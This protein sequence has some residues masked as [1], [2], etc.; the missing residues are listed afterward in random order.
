MA[1][2]LKPSFNSYGTTVTAQQFSKVQKVILFSLF[3]GALLMMTQT[4]YA[5]NIATLIADA[6]N[7]L[8]VALASVDNLTRGTKAIVIVIAFLGALIGASALKNA[9]AILQFVGVAIFAAIGLPVGLA[10]AG[11]VI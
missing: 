6:T 8:S 11:S 10:I 5:V 4:V 7:P 1:T 2:T 9:G 3:V